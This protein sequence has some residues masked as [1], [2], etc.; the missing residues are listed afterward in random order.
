MRASKACASPRVRR[1][2]LR[3]RGKKPRTHAA[4]LD[5]FVVLDAVVDVTDGGVLPIVGPDMSFVTCAQQKQ[6][7]DGYL[8]LNIVPAGESRIVVGESPRESG[9]GRA[10]DTICECSL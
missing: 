9:K 2:L 1:R 5:V 3:L 8:F 7:T 10:L 4:V 6:G